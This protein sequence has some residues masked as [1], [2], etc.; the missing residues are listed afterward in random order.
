MIISGKR[1]GAGVYF[2]KYA[3]YSNG[4]TQ[5]DENGFRTMFLCKVLTGDFTQGNP[6]LI[7]TP[8]KDSS[9]PDVKYDS[10]V[11]DMSK[12]IM[13]VIFRDDQAYPEYLIKYKPK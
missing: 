12:P 10:V 9:R 6:D 13:W 3:A 1:F 2:A 7:D 5:K 8:A 4:Y 11:D